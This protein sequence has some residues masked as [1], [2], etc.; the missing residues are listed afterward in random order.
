MSL[1]ISTVLNGSRYTLAPLVEA[2]CTR[3]GT[4]LRCSAFTTITYRPLRSVTTCSWRYFEV[5]LP[6]R[7]ASSVPRSFVFCRRNRSR[8]LRNRG[9]ASST[10]SP[11][12]SMAVRTRA[13]SPWN[14]AAF[15]PARSTRGNDEATR[16]IAVHVSSTE[17]RNEASASSRSA[18]SARPST[19]TA[20]RISGNSACARS[21]KLPCVAMKRA[22]SVV[23]ASRSAT[24]RRS[25][26][27]VNRERRSSPIG[28][29]AKPRTASTIRS[30]SSARRAAVCI[31]EESATGNGEPSGREKPIL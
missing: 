9:L 31:S 20:A 21:G 5:S 4:S 1:L 19:A 2:P 30:N 27:G 8:T 29:C 28:V 18:S 14:E 24:S 11:D 22:V 15:V 25:V 3:P 23:E 17:S 26:D 10:T 13:V 16:R 7:Y 6:R 12:E